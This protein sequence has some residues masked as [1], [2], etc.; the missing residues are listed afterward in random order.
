MDSLTFIGT[1]IIAAF[2]MV[3]VLFFL[4]STERGLIKQV[5]KRSR[6]P[7][8]KAQGD[9]CGIC[10]GTISNDDVITKCTCSQTFHRS[11]AEPTGKCP[12]CERPYDELVT[13]SPECVVCPSCGADVVGNVCSCNAVINREGFICSCGN[14]LDVNDPKCSKCGKEYEVRS[15]RRV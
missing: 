7:S 10:F 14:K 12:Y 3:A 13:E 15:G 6:K 1:A 2:I 4:F 11:C 9:V 5:K 8:A